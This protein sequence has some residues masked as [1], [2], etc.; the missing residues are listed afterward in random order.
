MN[1]QL[2]KAISFF[3]RETRVMDGMAV[4][5][6]RLSGSQPARDGETGKEAPRAP[7]EKG[8]CLRAWDGREIGE[9][10]VYDLASVTK[11][12]TG[13]CLMRLWELGK[14]D[15]FRRVTWYCPAFSRLGTAT[16]EQLMGFQLLLRTPD[17]IDRQSGRQE[18]Q[19]CLRETEVAGVPGRRAYSDIPPMILKYVIEKASDQP[20]ANCVQKLILEPAGME[21]TWARVPEDRIPDCLLYGPEYRIERENRICRA[22]IRRGIPHDPKAAILQGDSGD[23]CGHAG[24][25]STLGDMERLALALLNGRILSPESMRRLA[26]NR[27]GRQLSAGTY[28]QYLGYCCYL[29]HPNQYFSEIPAGMSPAAFGIAG[30]TGNHF[31]VDPEGKRYTLFLGN[32][33]RDR[34]TVLIPP[35]GKT[36]QDFGLR[37]D[38]TGEIRWTDGTVHA[39]SVDYV[40]LK[41]AHLHAVIEDMLGGNHP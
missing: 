25:F 16:V 20:M 38:G 37:A 6:G 29:K 3:T 35:E 11:I 39:S 33:V 19:A 7:G 5:C 14:L 30:F 10:T 32:R 8:A 41:D 1:E 2:L 23:L 34:L 17:R 4:S 12:F 28:T 24:L 13:I 22:E 31:S 18:A 15:P 9:N 27:T 26:V 21:N 36:R 40:H